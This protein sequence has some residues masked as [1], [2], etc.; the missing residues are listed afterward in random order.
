M[1]DGMKTV[2]FPVAHLGQSKA[3]FRELLGVEPYV[4]EAYY[5][6]F[7]AGGQEIGLDPNGHSKGLTAPVGYWEVQDIDASVKALT[8]AGADVFQP[9]EH[10][11]G[12]K[13]I[14]AV[15]DADGNV[16]GLVQEP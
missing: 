3:L 15:Q 16:I 6:G 1:T 2:I 5:V 9:V 4:D 8:D 14:A 13:R 12:G 11:G 10:V 7:R